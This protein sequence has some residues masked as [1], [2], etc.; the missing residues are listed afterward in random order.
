MPSGCMLYSPRFFSRMVPGRGT[1]LTAKTRR[2]LG[3]LALS[4]G[5][6]LV[7]VAVATYVTWPANAVGKYVRDRRAHQDIVHAL[8]WRIGAEPDPV[9]RGFYQA[10]LAE[11]TGDLSGAIRAFEAVQAATRPGTALYLKS[12]LRLGLAQGQNH[13]P[14]KELATYRSLMGQYPGA[15]R[16]SQAT[17][18]LRQG[19]TNR[20]RTLLQDALEQDARDGS[21]GTYRRFARDLRD[22][23]GP[24]GPQPSAKSP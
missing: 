5:I 14:E 6:G 3:V 19:D 1:P 11:E 16:L 2:L 23:L 8:E 12:S 24:V 18:Y 10:W 13:E 22:G 4:S 15:S 7:G 9:S 20:A 17:F 21:L